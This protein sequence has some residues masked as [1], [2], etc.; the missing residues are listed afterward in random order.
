MA[1]AVRRPVS[2]FSGETP[3]QCHPTVKRYLD[4]RI[5]RLGRQ[6]DVALKANVSQTHISEVLNGKAEPSRDLLDFLGLERVVTYKRPAAMRAAT[7]A[8]VEKAFGQ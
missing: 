8:T 5:R 3:L 4:E 6:L 7:A 1:E 2:T